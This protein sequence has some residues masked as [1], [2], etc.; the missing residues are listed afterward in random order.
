MSNDTQKTFLFPVVKGRKVTVNFGGKFITG[1]AGGVL[2]A[3]ADKRLN[4]LSPMAQ[5][6]PDS[7]D[8]TKVQHT[9]E[10]MFKQRVYGIAL[11]YDDLNDHDPLRR[12]VAFQTIVGQDSELASSP[13]LCRFEN[14][15]NREIAV[16]INKKMVET[17]IGSFKEAPNELMLD[18]DGTENPIYGEQEGKY[19]NGFYRSNCFIPLHVF[20]GK[21]LLV[22]YLRTSKTGGAH[23]AWAILSLLV[24]RLRQVWPNVKIIFRAD[25]AFCRPEILSWCE[26]KAVG[27]ILGMAGNPRLLA[28][29]EP[30]M[31]MAEKAFQLTQTKQRMFTKFM[32]AANTWPAERQMIGKAEHTERGAN[33]RFVVTNLMQEAPGALV[34]ESEELYDSLYCL[35]GDA[36]NRIK[37]LKSDLHAGRTSAHDWWPNQLRAL[38]SALAYVLLEYIRRNALAETDLANA[39]MGTI[40]SKLFKIGA[41]ASKTMHRVH[42]TLSRYDPMQDIFAHVY[43]KLVDT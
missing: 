18:F 37:D 9:V 21:A 5:L 42:F 3:A 27:Y 41:I 24:K 31:K 19:Y 25:S 1:N 14:D 35:R 23:H 29:L 39:Q 15:A 40:R 20:C 36:E 30:K 34:D 26:R 28:M 2:L 33:P 13:T 43:S 10:T 12:D 32:Y 17:F 11:G 38:L 6:F 22:S 7:R 4:L 8:Q 16:A